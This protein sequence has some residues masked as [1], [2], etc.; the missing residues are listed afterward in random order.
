MVMPQY[1]H[2]SYS[3][4]LGS[5][6]DFLL[7]MLLR[8]IAVYDLDSYTPRRLLMADVAKWLQGALPQPAI[9]WGD[10][11]WGV[12]REEGREGISWGGAS[13]VSGWE[14]EQ[15]STGGNVGERSP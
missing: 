7:Q 5:D 9:V 11:M 14:S 13:T 3:E 4:I 8:N 10:S 2:P 15:G 1:T 6:G 12:G